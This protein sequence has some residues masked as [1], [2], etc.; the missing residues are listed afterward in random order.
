MLQQSVEPP[1][2]PFLVLSEPPMVQGMVAQ[3]FNLPDLRGRLPMGAGTGTGLNSS[4]T[5][6]TFWNSTNS[7]N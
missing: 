4:G 7:K 2:Q 3:S 6:F 5:W 1:M